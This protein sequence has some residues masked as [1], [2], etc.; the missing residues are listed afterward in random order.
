MNFD[1]GEVLSR[2]WQITW[3]HKVLWL[4]NL[5]PMLVL[6]LVFPILFIFF[7]YAGSNPGR[8]ENSFENPLLVFLLITFYI[9]IFVVGYALNTIARSSTTLGVIRAE[10]GIGSTSFMDLLRDGLQ[11]FWRMIGVLLLVSLTIG[12]VFFVFF[13]CIMGFILVTI[14]MGA[15]CAQPLMLLMMPFSLLV[16]AFMEQAEA[17]VIADNKTV[18]DA[19]RLALDLIKTHIWKYVLITLIV[20]FGTTFVTYLVMFPLMIPFF[21]ISFLGSLSKE[22]LRSSMWVIGAFM[23]I[24]IPVMAFVQGITITFM[25]STL[26]IMYL[27]LTRGQQEKL[28]PQMAAS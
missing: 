9:F 8:I 19:T 27:R 6:F 26:T 20:Y 4:L 21:G 16:M 7:L 25:K 28:E 22:L 24:F 14:G 3:K 15:I 13:A 17:A 2:A 1:F 12:L 10:E 23:L 5:L 18:L 11:Y